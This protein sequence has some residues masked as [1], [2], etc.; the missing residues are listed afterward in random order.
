[1]TLAEIMRRAGNAGASRSFGE[2]IERG[3]VTVIPVALVGGG[4][5]GGEDE[6]PRSP[7]VEDEHEGRRSSGG[8]WG[9]FSY[10]L[11]AYVIANGDVR[12]VPAWDVTRIAVALLGLVKAISKLVEGR[13][14]NR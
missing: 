11:G 5:G 1:M 12:F 3:G 8:G 6:R 10:P 2:P 4:G 14:K 13:R 9:G 7:T